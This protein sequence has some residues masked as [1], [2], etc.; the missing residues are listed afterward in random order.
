MF[1]EI[2][3]LKRLVSFATVGSFL[4]TLGLSQ[5]LLADEAE[6]MRT[7]NTL[8]NAALA[9]VGDITANVTLAT[10]EADSAAVSLLVGS[11]NAARLLGEFE[12]LGGNNSK[13][14]GNFEINAL[15]DALNGMTTQ[16]VDGNTLRTVVPLTFSPGCG[17]CHTNYAVEF[18]VGDVVGAAS[19]KVS[20]N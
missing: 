1:K 7:T 17:V 18:N 14:H 8:A 6:A 10:V 20:I 3:M 11:N 15:A 4:L 2:D 16:E 5:N 19:F 9:A 12:P 13:P